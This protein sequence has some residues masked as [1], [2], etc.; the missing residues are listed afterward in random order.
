[1][2]FK[3]NRD[4]VTSANSFR[5]VDG[6]AWTNPNFAGIV[7]SSRYNSGSDAMERMF[8]PG[9]FLGNGVI[10]AS[11]ELVDAFGMDNG[12]PIAD[13]TKRGGYNPANPYVNRDPRFSS[14]IF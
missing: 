7:F 2:V 13:P 8:Y 9:G 5:P 1:M 12:Y 6:V 3:Q 14:V 10:G 11:E 4:Q